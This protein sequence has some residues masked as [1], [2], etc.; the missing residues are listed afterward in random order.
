MEKQ[1]HDGR[2]DED[3]V[4]SENSGAYHPGPSKVK[5]MPTEELATVQSQQLDL[6]LEEFPDGPYGAATNAPKLG[7]STPWREGQAVVSSFRDQNPVSSDRKV[8]L[9]EPPF[10]APKG[11]I[12]GQN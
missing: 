12:E 3:I 7:K 4:A 2:T 1:P 11:S 9:D 10:D 6:M 5:E 8:A